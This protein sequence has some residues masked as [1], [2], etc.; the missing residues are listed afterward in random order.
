MAVLELLQTAD[1]KEHPF[2]S[3]P[4]SME[5]TGWAWLDMTFSSWAAKDI[6]SCAVTVADVIESGYFKL[7]SN[8]K[9]IPF[10]L[11]L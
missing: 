5:T 6:V 2:L 1:L 8:S 3:L 10:L 9:L 7:E 4:K 11:E